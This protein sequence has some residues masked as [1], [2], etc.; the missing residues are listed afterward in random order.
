M[1]FGGALYGE[2]N[3]KKTS[4]FSANTDEYSFL[5]FVKLL[6]HASLSLKLLWKE[7]IGVEFDTEIK[8]LKILYYSIYGEND[9]VTLVSLGKEF[10]K[11]VKASKKEIFIIENATHFP[12]YESPK[13]FEEIMIKSIRGNLKKKELEAY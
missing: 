8:K 11:D 9:Y 6:S 7:I 1:Y 13:K 5:D 10:H 4:Q 12:Q 2:K 3:T